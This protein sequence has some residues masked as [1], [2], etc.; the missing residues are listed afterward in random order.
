MKIES[1]I[2]KFYKPQF[3]HPNNKSKIEASFINNQIN[4]ELKQ[5]RNQVKADQKLGGFRSKTILDPMLFT[6]TIGHPE[7][8]F[9][10][11]YYYQSEYNMINA[12]E[13][14]S[15]SSHVKGED[16]YVC[17]KHSYM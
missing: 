16:C 2:H 8:I 10:T 4:N 7:L 3:I 14:W 17:Q 1:N 15:Y 9:N 6:R 5:V 11:N 12:D 13:K